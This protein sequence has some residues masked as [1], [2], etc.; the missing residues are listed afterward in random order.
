L[1]LQLIEVC[2]THS[3]YHLTEHELELRLAQSGKGKR[4]YQ[5]IKTQTAMKTHPRK[6]M[7]KHDLEITKYMLE[8]TKYMF[9]LS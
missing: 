5:D 3:S 4:T 9:F 7:N 8:I 6:Q 2:A 1:R